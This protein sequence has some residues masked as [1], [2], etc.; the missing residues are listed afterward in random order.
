MAQIGSVTEA[1]VRRIVREELAALNALRNRTRNANYAATLKA[2][3]GARAV[4]ERAE[5][6][7]NEGLSAPSPKGG[8]DA[9]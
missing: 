6:L 5:A 9:L 1:D 8:R 4:Q 3:A 2:E 7:P